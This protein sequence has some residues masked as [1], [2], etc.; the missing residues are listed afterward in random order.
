MSEDLGIAKY[1][2]WVGKTSHVN[3]FFDVSDIFVLSS[4][5]E[6]F[7]LV[8]L[9]AMSRRTPILASCSP[10]IIEILGQNYPGLFPIGDSNSLAKLLERCREAKFLQL[11]VD[12]ANKRIT[13]F[14]PDNMAREIESI[15][16]ETLQ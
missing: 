9:E 10:A 1:I 15:Y 4:K 5:Y 13:L 11:L 2:S 16:R 7:G 3:T 14:N 8:I 6:G 12:Q